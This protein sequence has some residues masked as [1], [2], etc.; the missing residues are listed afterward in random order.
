MDHTY[1]L[2]RAAGGEPVRLLALSTGSGLVYAANPDAMPRVKS[3]ES[4]PVGFP[5]EDVFQ[6]D[7]NA[8][9][10]LRQQWERNWKLSRSEWTKFNL[11]R[12]VTH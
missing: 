8:F 6:F 10:L 7:G 12:F 5:A 1:V 11:V 9:L 2:V 4:W 3:G